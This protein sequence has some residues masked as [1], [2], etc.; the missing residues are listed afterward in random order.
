MGKARQISGPSLEE[1]DGALYEHLDHQVG[2]PADTV[3]SC[4]VWVKQSAFLEAFWNHHPP[5]GTIIL[6][7]LS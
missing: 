3:Q 7:K 6:S 1:L 2:A 5:S 4:C